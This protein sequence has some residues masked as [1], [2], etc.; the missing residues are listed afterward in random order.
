M[1]RCIAPKNRDHL[2]S[3][4]HSPEDERHKLSGIGMLRH[5][6]VFYSAPVPLDPIGLHEDTQIP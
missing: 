5:A 3:R 6:A 2:S 4:E 1:P